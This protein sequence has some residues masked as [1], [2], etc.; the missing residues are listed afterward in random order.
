MK[1]KPTLSVILPGIRPQNW[2]IVYDG[3]EKAVGD[4]TWELVAIGPK[5]ADL[6]LRS[7]K[8]IFLEDYGSPCHCQ[9]RALLNCSGEYITWSADDGEFLPGS[10]NH[11]FS[12]DA[13]LCKYVE[14]RPDLNDSRW[15]QP[16]LRK[17][18]PYCRGPV[19]LNP[20]M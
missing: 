1:P 20:E 8:Y 2:Q 6:N 16:E 5:P 7:G 12:A 14:G 19:A 4:Y 15:L 18:I 11:E 9:Q 13:I 17:I 3:I 10:L